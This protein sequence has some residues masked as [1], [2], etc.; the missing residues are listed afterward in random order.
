MLLDKIWFSWYIFDPVVLLFPLYRDTDFRAHY[1]EEVAVPAPGKFHLHLDELAQRVEAVA[2]TKGLEIDL[3]EDDFSK[4]CLRG[5]H[6]EL[7]LAVHHTIRAIN[8]K[9]E[10]LIND[11]LVVEDLPA[12]ILTLAQSLVEKGD[13][14]NSETESG[15][16]FMLTVLEVAIRTNGPMTAATAR[17]T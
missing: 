7:V 14:S 13:P 5:T 2:L 11:T 4:G 17:S 16:V 10:T 8:P 12:A 9:L 1:H 6:D 3:S 15:V